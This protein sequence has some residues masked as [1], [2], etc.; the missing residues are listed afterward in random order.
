V[1]PPEPPNEFAYPTPNTWPFHF[2]D[3]FQFVPVT[4]PAPPAPPRQVN[5][6]PPGNPPLVRDPAEFATRRGELT[7]PG[8]IGGSFFGNAVDVSLDL[9]RNARP[10]D[11]LDW[12]LDGDPGI[13][14]PTWQEP[15]PTSPRSASTPET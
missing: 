11:F 15:S 9:I 5:P 13:G 1:E 10:D 14:F 4:P 12:D 3:G 7:F 8:A 6:I 2:V